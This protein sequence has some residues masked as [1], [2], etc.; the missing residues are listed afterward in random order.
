MSA[1]WSH[2]QMLSASI[3]MEKKTLKFSPLLLLFLRLDPRR[4]TQR[5]RHLVPAE[6][7][8]SEHSSGLEGGGMKGRKQGKQQSLQVAPSKPEL[9][10]E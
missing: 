10:R 1:S 5:K 9:W 6:V 4:K 3:Q 2:S 7:L 8:H